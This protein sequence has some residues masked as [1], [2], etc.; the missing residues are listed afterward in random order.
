MSGDK[1]LCISKNKIK[2]IFVFVLLIAGGIM[3]FTYLSNNSA[4]AK[5]IDDCLYYLRKGDWKMISYGKCYRR[6]ISPTQAVTPTCDG[7]TD[8][9]YN[10]YMDKIK[11][12]CC[13]FMYDQ[14]KNRCQ[15]P[16]AR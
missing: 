5:P 11:C 7:I 15:E 16:Y 3:F 1:L 12:G 9:R 13:G 10:P 2:L 8:C 4:N 14:V 6:K